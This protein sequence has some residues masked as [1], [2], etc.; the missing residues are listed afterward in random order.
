[1]SNKITDILS[2][3]ADMESFVPL[4]D[5]LTETV[6]ACADGELLEEDLLFVSAAGSAPGYESF[7]KRFHLD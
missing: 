7:L 5:D 4:G 1:M 2:L 6:S 3:T